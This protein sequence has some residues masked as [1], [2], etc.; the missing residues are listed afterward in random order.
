LKKNDRICGQFAAGRKFAGCA[1]TCWVLRLFLVGTIICC[2]TG[3]TASM[4]G[5]AAPDPA[6]GLA[7]AS[8]PATFTPEIG[9]RQAAVLGVV[10]GLTEYLPVSSTGHLILV[11]HWLQLSQFETVPGRGAELVKAPGLDAFEIVIQLGAILAVLG[12]Y[13]RHVWRIIQGLLGR[14][15]EGLRLLLNL[16]VA[17]LPAAVLGLA[18]RETIKTL[19]FSPLTVAIALAVGGGV[20][21]AAERI[22]Y[23][24]GP[25]RQRTTDIVKITLRQ[26]FIIGLCQCLALCPGT[27]RS[28]VTILGGIIVGLDMVT[29]AG[30]SFLLAL[31]TLGGAT[32]YE[33]IREWSTLGDA[34]GIP[35]LL[36]GIVV[37]GV[38]A[39]LTMKW[40]L[41]WLTRHGLAPFGVYRIVLGTIVFAALV[42]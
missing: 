2:I 3:A 18:L 31:P 16:A 28:M 42:L 23:R 4:S 41:H 11:S 6:S 15:R 26:A 30:F 21:I 20:M 37:S 9:F 14:D 29:A 17:F 5:T 27:S 22:F 12:L 7:P 38:V 8:E 24:S 25:V 40:L 19:L 35:G 32:F 1:R 13:R 39:A 36:I 10:E 33:G 34:V